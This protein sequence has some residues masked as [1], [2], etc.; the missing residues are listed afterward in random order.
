M[1]NKFSNR[2]FRV[3]VGQRPDRDNTYNIYTADH[4][5]SLGQHGLMGKQSLYEHAVA[6]DYL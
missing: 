2:R 1:K 5:L 4:G 3:R 6:A